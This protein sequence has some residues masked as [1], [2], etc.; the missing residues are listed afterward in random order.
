VLGDDCEEVAEQ[1]ALIRCQLARD[2]VRTRRARAA[3]D[4]ADARVAATILIAHG[5]ITSD[6]VAVCGVG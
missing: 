4:L 5:T 1:G 6:G 2:R 3:V